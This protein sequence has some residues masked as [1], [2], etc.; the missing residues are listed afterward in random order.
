MSLRDELMPKS[1]PIE[2]VTFSAIERKKIESAFLADQ[3]EQFLAMGGK[4]QQIP[5]GVIAASHYVASEFTAENAAP[6]FQE[7]RE[8]SRK[9]CQGASMKSKD[10]PTGYDGIYHSDANKDKFV[11]IIGKYIS[12]QFD[13][14]EQA[15]NHQTFMRNNKF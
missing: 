9:K 11:V 7:G 6:Q 4:A 13:K 15:I 2:A 1:Q 14:I 3:V 8:N 10:N 5:V 12:K